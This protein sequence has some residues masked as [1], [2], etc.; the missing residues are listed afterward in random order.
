MAKCDLYV[1]S[2]HREGFSTA[3]TEAL[4]VGTPVIST[5]CSGAHELLGCHNE[6]GMIV[7]NS[8]KGIYQGMKQ[9]LNNPE[10]LVEMKKQAEKRGTFFSREKTVQAVEKMFKSFED[11]EK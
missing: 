1:C 11:N 8:T 4:V 7:E 3:V 6:Y 9:V 10:M 2:S 5:L